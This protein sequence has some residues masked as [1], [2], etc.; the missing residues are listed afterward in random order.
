MEAAESARSSRKRRRKDGRVDLRSQL[1]V[2][3][4]PDHNLPLLPYAAG[5]QPDSNATSLR[6][7]GKSTLSETCLP[8]Y[9]FPPS[10]TRLKP[11]ALDR[12]CWAP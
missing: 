1:E 9:P 2:V 6:Q 11:A 5:V 4:E 10:W 7:A 3:E 12:Q 8:P